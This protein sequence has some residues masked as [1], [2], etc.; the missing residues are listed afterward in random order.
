MAVACPI[1][2]TSNMALTSDQLWSTCNNCGS[3][4]FPKKGI[5]VVIAH[6]SDVIAEELGKALL[7]GGYTPYRA[8][9]GVQ[10]QELIRKHEVSVVVLDVGLRDKLAYQI[11]DECRRTPQLESI[12]FIL[13]ASVY[14]KTAYKRSPNS[15]YGAD[16]YVEQH[17]IPDMLCDKIQRLIGNSQD[18]TAVENLEGRKEAIRIGE[19]RQDLKGGQRVIVLAHSIVADIALYNQSEVEKVATGEL[20]KALESALEEGRRI[21]RETVDQSSFPTEDPIGD[22]FESFINDI[23]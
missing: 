9:N 7:N 4:I 1:C 6:E 14:S 18:E 19:E 10:A 2:S 17:H 20:S 23:R 12:K 8:E 21:L 11:V 13:L 16:D 5:P 3:M 22:A 15:L